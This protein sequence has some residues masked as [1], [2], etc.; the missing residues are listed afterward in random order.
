MVA[1]SGS[2]DESAIRPAGPALDA[3]LV[4]LVT[5]P[6]HTTGTMRVKR[7]TERL[8]GNKGPLCVIANLIPLNW[9]SRTPKAI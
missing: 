5:P 1:A 2:R 4:R 9:H 8:M 7:Q 3:M 6:V